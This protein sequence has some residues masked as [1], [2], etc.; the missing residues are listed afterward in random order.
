MF[1]FLQKKKRRSTRADYRV[2]EGDD[3][4][5][6]SQKM[7]IRLKYLYQRNGMAVGA[8]PA[9]GQLLNLR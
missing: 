9:V 5:L 6:I 7:G 1:V 8:Q 3:M 4:Y 2:Q